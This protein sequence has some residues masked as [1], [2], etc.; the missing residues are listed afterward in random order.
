[1]PKNSYA[2]QISKAQVM[3]AGLKGNTVQ[4]GRRGL[5]EAFLTKF[6]ADRNEAVALNDAQEKLKA[7]LVSK[8]AQLDSKLLELDKQVSEAQKIVKMDFEQ[9]H[10]KEFGIPAKR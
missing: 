10:W 2:E 1:M 3:L 7:D 4:I 5:D 6:E 9:S 8:T